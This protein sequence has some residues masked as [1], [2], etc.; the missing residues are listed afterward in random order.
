MSNENASNITTTYNLNLSTTN[1]PKDE[2]NAINCYSKSHFDKACIDLTKG[3]LFETDCANAIDKV[4]ICIGN[5]DI[6]K[7]FA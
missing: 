7:T 2:E 1:W 3:C 4:N 5:K 6:I